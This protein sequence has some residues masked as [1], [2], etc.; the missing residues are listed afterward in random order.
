MAQVQYYA[1]GRRKE[2]IAGC[3]WFLG[4]AE[5]LSTVGTWMNTSAWKP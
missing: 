3:G 1:T 4:T 5:S 2:S